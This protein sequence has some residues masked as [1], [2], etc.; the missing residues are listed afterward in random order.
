M[1]LRGE[2]LMPFVSLSLFE[3]GEGKTREQARLHIAGI[4]SARL[5]A[6]AGVANF[7]TD[8]GVGFLV[9]TNYKIQ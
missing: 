8:F 2:R 4:I 5:H 6:S 7:D 1:P 3:M 9:V